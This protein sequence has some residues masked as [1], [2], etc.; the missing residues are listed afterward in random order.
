[1][2]HVVILLGLC[3]GALTLCS[4]SQANAAVCAA[5]PYRAGCVGPR[6]VV[7]GHRGYYG[8]TVIRGGAYGRTVV[9]RGVYGRT[10]IRRRR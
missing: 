8:R 10:V 7:V 4:F 6:G 9:R 5:G 3:L 1:V 2:R